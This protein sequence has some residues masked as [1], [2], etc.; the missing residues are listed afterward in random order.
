MTLQ[1]RVSIL[2]SILLVL[3]FWDDWRR[4]HAPA[5]AAPASTLQAAAAAQAAP[6]TQSSEKERV[7][8]VLKCADG[9]SITQTDTRHGTESAT[10]PVAASAAATAAPPPADRLG[11][12][13]PSNYSVTVTTNPLRLHDVGASL[14]IRLGTLPLSV[15][16]GA[17]LHSGDP[18]LR[19]GL[20]LDL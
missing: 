11:E 2:L 6:Q 19:A 10:A 5:P 20:R 7:T 9:T 3:C 12:Y 8:T 18:E 15:E 13:S 1:T 4:A 17:E 14:G 16:V